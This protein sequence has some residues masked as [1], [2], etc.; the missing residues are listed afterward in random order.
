MDS[1][2][3]RRT[4]FYNLV[5]LNHESRNYTIQELSRAWML[6]LSC[7]GDRIGVLSQVRVFVLQVVDQPNRGCR[8]CRWGLL[9]LQLNLSCWRWSQVSLS[10]LPNTK[11]LWPKYWSWYQPAWLDTCLLSSSRVSI[12]QDTISPAQSWLF[13]YFQVRSTKVL[14]PYRPQYQPAWLDT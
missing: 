11:V 7:D 13:W 4:D 3:K 6:L 10:L 2:P 1:T 14:W 12:N 5:F 9:S 8:R